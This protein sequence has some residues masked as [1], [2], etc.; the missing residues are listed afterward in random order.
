MNTGF[1]R[2][3][4][5]IN[6]LTEN[7]LKIIACLAMFL[8]HLVKAI[9]LPAATTFICSAVIGRIAF[10]LFCFFLTEGFLHT[11]NI[12]RYLLRLLLLAFLSE[13]PF[14]LALSGTLYAPQH[15]NTLFTLF[16]GLSLLF[17]IRRIESRGGLSYRLSVLCIF[18]LFLVFAAAAYFLRTDYGAQGIACITA[19]YLF[20]TRIPAAG[21]K[22]TQPL[23]PVFWGCV[24]LNLD[25]L[26]EP[27]AF[28]SLLP[29]VF[30]NG[31]RG[32]SAWKYF[33]YLF[34]PLHL[35]L[36]YLLAEFFI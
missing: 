6:G 34:Y 10:P 4:Y 21:K 17:C 32:S 35:L 26:S 36:L 20:R 8:D 2:H 18:L 25:F 29:L 7:A 12:R 9:S 13:I 33:F 31:R 15:Q 23:F 3:T 24:M 5:R 28:L 1:I 19:I 14:D 16:L 27:A 11:R 22:K 30:Y